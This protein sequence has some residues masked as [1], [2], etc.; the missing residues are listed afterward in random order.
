MLKPWIASL[1]L[2]LTGA[3]AGAAE[4]PA[5]LAWSQRVTLSTPASGIVDSIPVSAGQRVDKG[6]L[7]LSLDLR[8]FDSALR[9]A[10]AQVRKHKLNRDEAERELERTRELYERTVI[11]VHDLQLQEIATATAEADYASAR[12]RLESA[13]LDREHAGI[14]APFAGVVLD[15]LVTAGETV[16]NTQQATPMVVL[17]GDRPMVAETML[18]ADSLQG[19]SA[20]VL[21]GQHRYEGKVTEIAG[22]PDS[23]GRYRVKVSFE[24]GDD[25]L[26]AGLPARVTLER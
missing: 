13:Q 18:D 16:V 11:S 26:R 12:A 25:T 21:A 10:T 9:Y 22:E 14:R 4:Y 8:P 5:V 24:P 15:T 19:L 23:K 20:G 17:A 1:V 7:L 6:Q 3:T 2:A